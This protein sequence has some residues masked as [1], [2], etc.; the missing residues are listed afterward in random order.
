MAT[1]L[2]LSGCVDNNVT[3]RPAFRF[4]ND[5]LISCVFLVTDAS[6]S[7]APKGNGW[8]K[9][10][11]HEADFKDKEGTELVLG[12]SVRRISR[13]AR[14]VDR[15]CLSRF[16]GVNQDHIGEGTGGDPA[17]VD[18]IQ[19]DKGFRG[20]MT[21]RAFTL[22]PQRPTRAAGKTATAA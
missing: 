13:V 8:L 1:D 15:Q 10:K 6:K 9:V 17:L 12:P 16:E 21:P 2:R 7:G 14:G 18:R 3:G 11:V 20:S 5:L 19:R 22:L 4:H